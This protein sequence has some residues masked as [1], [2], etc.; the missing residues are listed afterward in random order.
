MPKLIYNGT[1]HKLIM[2]HNYFLKTMHVSRNI[3]NVSNT[4]KNVHFLIT[5]LLPF[6]HVK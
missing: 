4:S 3:F 1:H 5:N 2:G 6:P